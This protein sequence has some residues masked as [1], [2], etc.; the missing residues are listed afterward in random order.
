MSWKRYYCYYYQQSPLLALVVHF[1]GCWLLVVFVFVAVIHSI[2]RSFCIQLR[3]LC[4]LCVFVYETNKVARIRNRLHLNAKAINQATTISIYFM[5]Y[6]NIV[7]FVC[8]AVDILTTF[9]CV[10]TFSE[11]KNE[12]NRLST[13]LVLRVRYIF[14]FF[15]AV[16]FPLQNIVCL[17]V[18]FSLRIFIVFNSFESSSLCSCSCNAAIK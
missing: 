1:V 17:S 10:N 3:A 18:F 4:S 11:E 5:C 15:C 16:D 13:T 6:F 2:F 14:I 9:T 12:K 7:F 8:V